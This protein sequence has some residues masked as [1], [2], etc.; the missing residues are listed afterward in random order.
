MNSQHSYIE[1]QLDS[2]EAASQPRK[3]ELDRLVE[4][5]KIIS[6]EEKEIVKFIQGSKAE[7]EGG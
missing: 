3:D 1:K 4:L 2:L 5:K 6:K 7:R